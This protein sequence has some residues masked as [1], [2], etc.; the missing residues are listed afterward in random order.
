MG[1]I[2]W[3]LSHFTFVP[4]STII[5]PPTDGEMATRDHPRDILFVDVFMLMPSYL[6]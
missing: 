3:V 4:H 5:L 2:F 6:L 1:R